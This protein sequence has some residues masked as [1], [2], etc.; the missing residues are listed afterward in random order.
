MLLRRNILAGAAGLPFVG[1]ARAQGKAPVIKIG[2]LQDGSGPYSH[3]GGAGSV[4][5]ARLA[6]DEMAAQ[7]GLNV[8]LLVADHQNKPDVGAAIARQW[9]DDGVDA[10][11]E[12]NNSAIALAVNN[13]VRD[14]D[15][16]MLANNVGSAL[17]SGKQCSPNM[18]HW[19]F[20]TAELA[21]VMGTALTAQGGDTWYFIRADYVFGNS[22]QDDTA[23]IVKAKGGKILGDS[24]MPLGTSDYASALL[25]AQVSG[26]KV[27][28]FALAG[29][30][31]LN[32]V[33]QAAEIGI[34]RGGRQKIG[35]LI[36][37]WQDAHALGLETAQGLQ[38]TE[39]FYWDVNDR[40]RAFS[41][42]IM[43][44][45][46][47]MPPNM[48]QAGA[49]SAVRHYLKAVA[50]LGSAAAKASGRATVTRMKQIPIEDDVLN[51]ASIRAD[52][53]VVS[54]VYL[55]EV[56]KPSESKSEFD[57]YTLRATIGPDDAWRP[58]SEGGCPLVGG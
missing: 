53:R 26:A 56:K 18:T 34:G 31:L 32:C 17:L 27:I 1:R 38:L 19:T 22:L 12:F 25:S 42:R 35:A 37:H 28:A 16:V 21:R 46:K 6:I 58:M 51:N 50:A 5:C 48:G 23:A 10:L 44:H 47:G 41:K 45:T 13:M 29:Q 54:D 39:S 33:K 2:S 30:D 57:L 20:D 40:S 43:P 4:A 8:E 3:L 24:A 55:F 36:M 49:Y 52:G 15:K 14:R 11:L 9:L 7:H